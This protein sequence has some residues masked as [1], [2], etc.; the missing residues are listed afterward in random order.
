MGAVIGITMK[1]ISKV[2]R[3]KPSMNMMNITTATAASVP[4]G[5]FDRNSCTR[6]SPPIRRNTMENTEAPNRM[7]KTMQV[8]EAVAM[9]VSRSTLKDRRMRTAART[10]APTAPTEAASVGVAMPP[11]IEPRTA[12]ISSKGG[13]S[14]T[15][16]SPNRCFLSSG[17]TG[18]AGQD[19]GSKIALN[20]VQPR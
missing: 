14:A 8:I 11:R 15:P 20:T 18:V 10:I 19:C 7:M 16:T 1:M 3:M 17:A 9:A 6:L 5:R 2:S 12:M 13:T 4:P